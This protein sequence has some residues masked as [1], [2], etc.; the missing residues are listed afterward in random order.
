MTV[1]LKEQY[2]RF[3]N[4]G[5]HAHN[6][7]GLKYH[8]SNHKLLPTLAVQLTAWAGSSEP[9]GSVDVYTSGIGRLN[10]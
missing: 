9:K 1:S 5:I 3:G 6:K 8:Q 7:W 2:V 10:P 4:L